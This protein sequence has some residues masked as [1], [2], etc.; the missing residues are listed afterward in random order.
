MRKKSGFTL[1]ELII[2]LSLTVVVLGVIY[3][4]FLTNTKTLTSTELGVDL[5]VEAQNIQD[6]IL[7]YGT[8]SNGISSIN[9][10]TLD[11]TNK[12]KYTEVIDGQNLSTSNGKL[13][14][15]EITLNVEGKLI[16]F[17]YD[18]SNKSLK[19]FENNVEIKNLGNNVEEIKLRPL[20]YK[21]NSIGNFYETKA[22]EFSIVL[23]AKKGYTNVKSP[24]SIIVKFRNQ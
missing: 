15:K 5:Q 20:D 12:Y 6:Q 23:S 10:I 9:N 7:K 2:T 22:L 1:I 11:A 21:M 3:T 8:E 13:N 16:S 14:V 24:L 18:S 17:K 19:I 4:F